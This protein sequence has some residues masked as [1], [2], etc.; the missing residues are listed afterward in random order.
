MILH[1]NGDKLPMTFSIFAHKLRAAGNV[2]YR[3]NVLTNSEHFL[4]YDHISKKF[5]FSEGASEAV[6][7]ASD[8]RRKK[9]FFYTFE[10]KYITF[11]Q[12]GT[13][14]DDAEKVDLWEIVVGNGVDDMKISHSDSTHATLHS[15]LPEIAKKF[16]L[17]TAPIDSMIAWH[18]MVF[19]KIQMFR[20]PK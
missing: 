20:W 6:I 12:D 5:Y 15:F 9:S 3:L 1:C 19:E 13:L 10:G 16:S 11:K 2:E 7:I 14:G 17:R 4:K 8:P 18:P